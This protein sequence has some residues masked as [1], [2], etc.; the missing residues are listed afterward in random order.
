MTTCHETVSA[1]FTLE[2][3]IRTSESESHLTRGFREIS[4]FYIYND[5]N[6]VTDGTVTS[7]SKRKK[8]G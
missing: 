6:Y 4:L 7:R 8:K 2:N 3:R 1:L 5:Q